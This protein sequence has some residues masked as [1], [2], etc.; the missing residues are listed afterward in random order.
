MVINTFCE[1]T[2][3]AIMFNVVKARHCS[4]IGYFFNLTIL[5]NLSIQLER[6]CH[7]E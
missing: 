1:K 2:E 3:G 7:W 5:I 6:V 4:L